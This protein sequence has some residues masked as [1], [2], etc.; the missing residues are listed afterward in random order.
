VSEPPSIVTVAVPLLGAVLQ[1]LIP[2]RAPVS[3]VFVKR[4]ELEPSITPPQSPADV[5]VAPVTLMM[6]V[7]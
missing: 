7:E 6:P 2:W 3:A 4:M 5:T 1:V